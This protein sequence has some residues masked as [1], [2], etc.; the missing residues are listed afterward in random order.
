MKIWQKATIAVTVLL[1]IGGIV[2]YS[3]YKA[4][5]N[6]VTV[7]TGR[8]ARQD[9]ISLVTASGEIRPKNY[10]N[11]LGEGIGKI[12]DIVVKEGDH[13]KKGDVLLHL[14]N[15]Q[16]GADVQAQVASI[17]AA[18]SG[19]KASGSNFDM[20][21]ATAA[22]RQADFT[23]AQ[24][25]WQRA[26]QLY[27][28]QLISK[29]DYDTAK[30]TY[31]SASAAATSANAQVDQARAS[32]EQ[33]RSNLEQ[34]RAVLRHTQ[35]ILRKTTYTAPI[36]GIVS[37]IAVRVG[38]NVVPGIQGTA[39][40]SILTISDMSIVTTEVKV[41][42]TDIVSIR[43][44]QPVEVT[45]DAIPD[46]TFK[47][48]VT[49]VGE[50]AILRTSGQASMTETTANTQEARDFKVVVTLDNPPD[51]LRPGLSATAKIQTAQK[52]NVMSIPI[53]ALAERSQKELDEAK[54]GTT[55]SNV[56]L[57]AS[58]VESASA[59]TD[60]QGVFVVRNGKAQFVPV[61][62]GIS[63]TTD[64]EITD[65]IHEG[66]VIVTGSFK[67]LRTLKPGASVKVDNSAPKTD[68]S[69]SSSSS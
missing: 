9:L 8:V 14:E 16:P 41:D 48:H 54:N 10:T 30:A 5:Q 32:R 31:D 68:E 39:G 29:Q 36:D 58:T 4:N 63:G 65:G 69:S 28:E 45:I 18:E 26:Q 22:Q 11:V 7:Q 42:E 37:Y 66:D 40:S 46:K 24:L 13:V 35:D 34:G 25:D 49:E 51:S 6:V 43:N 1:V 17:E 3:I 55:S 12:T 33:S 19:M 62:T 50:L 52:Q 67:A 60:I 57:A 38:E 64:I 44:G 20:A 61:K 59:K 27:K 56:T 53:Q 47:G 23:K 15:I 21:V 2:W